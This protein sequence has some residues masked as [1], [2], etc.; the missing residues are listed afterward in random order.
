MAI[1]PSRRI[2]AASG[3]QCIRLYDLAT[4]TL[5]V[6]FDGVV[7]NV[8]RIG[9][10]EDEKFMYTCGEDHRVR[11]WD[12]S[13]GNP[14]CK[15]IFASN[16]ALNAAVLL[17][18]QVEM[19]VGSQSGIVYIW[20]IKSDR[21]EAVLQVND[22]LLQDTSIQDIAVSPNGRLLAAVTNKGNCHIMYLI[23]GDGKLTT[24]MPGPKLEAHTKAY[25]LRCQ[26]SP[27]SQFLVTTG[28]DAVARIYKTEDF[29]FFAELKTESCRWVWDAAFTNDS[30]Y[31]F[32][33]SSDC[34][35]RLW[36]LA[37]QTEEREYIGHQK[38][39][40]AL[41]FKDVPLK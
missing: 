24:T 23:E 15:R 11:I 34:V 29:S 3:F 4:G 26:F 37:K 36:N 20:D 2:L 8:M 14:T 35:V 19:A 1:S 32:T 39:V 7:K 31:L 33:A 41:A 27:D 17:P 21:N 22:T 13:C 12:M 6:N 28:G 9:F 30:K 5:T 18:N 16:T 38:S 10:Q 40:T 25:A